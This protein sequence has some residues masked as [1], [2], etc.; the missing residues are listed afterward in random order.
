MNSQHRAEPLAEIQT[1][2]GEPAQLDLDP[3]W[4]HIQT[5]ADLNVCTMTNMVPI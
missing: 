1:A 5:Q 3:V 4:Q 2:A